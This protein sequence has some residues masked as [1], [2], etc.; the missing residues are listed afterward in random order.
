MSGYNSTMY[1]TIVAIIL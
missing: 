1:T